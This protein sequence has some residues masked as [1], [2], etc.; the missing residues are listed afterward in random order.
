MALEAAQAF[1]NEL[2]SDMMQGAAAFAFKSALN[3][4]KLQN[5]CLSIIIEG[6]I[7]AGKSTVL[8]ILKQNLD[9]FKIIEEPVTKWTNIDGV[10]LLKNFYQEPKKWAFPLQVWI[11]AT[12]IEAHNEMTKKPVKVMERSMYRYFVFALPPV[13][14]VV[15]PF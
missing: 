2:H 12:M 7:G 10:N 1:E 11:S 3:T 14:T 8:N 9:I 13:I 6:N 15:I 5:R 4:A